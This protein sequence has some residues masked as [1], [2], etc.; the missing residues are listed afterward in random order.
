MIPVKSLI[1]LNH[2]DFFLKTI[3][4]LKYQIADFNNFSIDRI[5]N[6]F[7]IKKKCLTKY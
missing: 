5:K 7:R 6:C 2:I 4:L 3:I 1:Y